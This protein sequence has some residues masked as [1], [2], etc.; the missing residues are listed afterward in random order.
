MP[1]KLQENILAMLGTL[2]MCLTIPIWVPL[3]ILYSTGWFDRDF[4]EGE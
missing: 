4:E 2:L 1:S 3:A